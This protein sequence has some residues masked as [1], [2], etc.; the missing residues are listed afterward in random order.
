MPG[1]AQQH[2]LGLAQRDA[3][4]LLEEQLENS[5]KDAPG[6]WRRKL[7]DATLSAQKWQKIAESSPEPSIGMAKVKGYEDAAHEAQ[8][9]L[10]D[11]K[12]KGST[13]ETLPDRFRAA[14]QMFAKIYDLES[15]TNPDT[16]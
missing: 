6:Y 9:M 15:V 7:D 8:M 5:V 12:S 14:R 16:G 4:K 10:N 13:L 1:D 11:A 3:A 2:A